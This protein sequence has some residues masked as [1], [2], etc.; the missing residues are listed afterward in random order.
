MTAYLYASG[1]GFKMIFVLVI[2]VKRT[3][4]SGVA[5]K[6]EA[7]HHEIF[8]PGMPLMEKCIYLFQLLPIF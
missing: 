8:F 4:S 1:G 3:N 2:D 7:P 6:F 5:L